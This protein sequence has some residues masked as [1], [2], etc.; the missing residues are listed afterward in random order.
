MRLETERLI[1]KTYK[2]EFADVIYPVVSQAEIA[3]TM[4]AIL[5]PYPKDY[6][7]KWIDFMHRSAKEGT[8]FEFAIFLRDNPE[9]Y[10]GT[11]GLL[12]ISNKHQKAEIG[13]FIDKNEWGK[14][15][16]SEAAS[17]MIHYGFEK[18]GLERIYGH[19]MSRNPASRKVMEKIGFQYEGRLRHG[20][21]KGACFE[22]LDLLGMIRADY[23]QLYR[24]EASSIITSFSNET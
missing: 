16:A 21:R 15:Y 12:S 9:K 11:C 14:G 22:D 10:I 3:D 8:A 17:S 24:A 23:E 20:V 18:L 5:H 19:C 2:H 7:N 4:I 1:L 6:V 13:C